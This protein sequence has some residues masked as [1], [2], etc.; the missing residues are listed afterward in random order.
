ML[1][2]LQHPGVMLHRALAQ[3][4]WSQM[5]GKASRTKGLMLTD[6]GDIGQGHGY[7][8]NFHRVRE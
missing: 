8:A 5:S 7:V 4:C 3:K 6:P 2:A 1:D